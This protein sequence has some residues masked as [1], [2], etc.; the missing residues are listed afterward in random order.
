MLEWDWYGFN[1][2]HARTSYTVLVFLHPVGFVGH[3]VHSD[4]CGVRNIIALF[5]I[6]GWDRYEFH[7]KPA[8]TRCAELIVSHLVGS[9]GHVVHSSVFG[10]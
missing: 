8:G 3:V 2:K 7:K 4:V 5:V 9:T 1:K 10:S 6:L